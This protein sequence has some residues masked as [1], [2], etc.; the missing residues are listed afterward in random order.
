M[1]V[2]EIM[3]SLIMADDYNEVR[4]NV[5][6]EFMNM[7]KTML[8]DF[9]YIEEKEKKYQELIKIVRSNIQMVLD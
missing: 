9:K 2:G 3:K 5:S 8:G 4:V 7:A 1:T 6:D